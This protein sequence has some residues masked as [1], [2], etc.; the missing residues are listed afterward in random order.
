LEH[1]EHT[2]GGFIF[3]FSERGMTISLGLSNFS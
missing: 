1:P 2:Y 3:A